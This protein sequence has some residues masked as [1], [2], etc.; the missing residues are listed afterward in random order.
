[1]PEAYESHLS[2][3]PEGPDSTQGRNALD[4]WTKLMRQVSPW[5]ND[6]GRQH[7]CDVMK[8]YLPDADMSDSF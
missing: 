6:A 1:M 7:W 5:Q 8:K 4:R 3:V 2:P